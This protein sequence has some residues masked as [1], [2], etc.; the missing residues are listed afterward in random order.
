[1]IKQTSSSRNKNMKYCVF[2]E[3]II[4]IFVHDSRICKFGVIE[5]HLLSNC[6][7]SRGFTCS[8]SPN[9]KEE[10]LC[11][12]DSSCVIEKWSTDTENYP[13][14]GNCKKDTKG[15]R[16]SISEKK[17]PENTKYSSRHTTLERR[18]YDVV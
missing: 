18:C 7:S 11:P 6:L 9:T 4:Q 8:S 15:K 13:N 14:L 16:T 2:C 5:S 3:L 17:P 12:R 1:M 10:I